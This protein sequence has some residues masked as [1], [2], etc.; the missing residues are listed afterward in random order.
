[1]QPAA[2]LLVWARQ[3]HSRTTCCAFN[4]IACQMQHL[5]LEASSEMPSCID[6]AATYVQQQ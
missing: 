1:M 2:L 4:R 5:L 6:R 3:Q